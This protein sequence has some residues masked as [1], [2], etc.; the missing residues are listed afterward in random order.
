MTAPAGAEAAEA[1]LL[2]TEPDWMPDAVN[3]LVLAS[4]ATAL[5]RAPSQTPSQTPSPVPPAVP[6]PTPPDLPAVPPGPTSEAVHAPPAP[7]GIPSSPTPSAG[8]DPAAAGPRMDEAPTRTADH[9]APGGVGRSE[10]AH[11]PADSAPLVHSYPAGTPP[12]MTRRGA[13]LALAGT[14]VAA[15]AVVAVW[16]TSDGG[17]G[18]GGR[19]GGAETWCCSPTRLRMARTGEVGTSGERHCRRGWF[20]QRFPQGLPG[21]CL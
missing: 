21:R 11:E 1:T 2:L 3:Q 6:T 15:G 8:A 9:L 7:P 20:E 18:A 14:A 16:K 17:F 12:P 19:H 5:P 13:L 10:P 4:T